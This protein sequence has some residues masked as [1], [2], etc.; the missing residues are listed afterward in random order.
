MP[1]PVDFTSRFAAAIGSTGPPP[2]EAVDLVAGA[3]AASTPSLPPPQE[4]V[5]DRSLEA[6]WWWAQSIAAEQVAFLNHETLDLWQEAT[7][8][9]IDCAQRAVATCPHDSPDRL[10]MACAAADLVLD[11][12]TY[13]P[14]AI[15]PQLPKIIQ[16]LDEHCALMPLA[17]AAPRRVRAVP[18]R[19]AAGASI[20]DALITLAASSEALE[21][22]T[23]TGPLA[24]AT[25]A[26]SRVFATL[27]DAKRALALLDQV[28]TGL[29]ADPA[30]DGT[31]EHVAVLVDRA[32]ALLELGHAGEAIAA[33]DEVLALP[34]D[35]LHP[36]AQLNR[37]IARLE[38][39]DAAGAEQDVETVVTAAGGPEPIGWPI[40]AYLRARIAAALDRNEARSA[41]RFAALLTRGMDLEW[42]TLAA[43][44]AYESDKSPTD[45]LEAYRTMAS[46]IAESRR[47]SLGYRL[48][49]T[50]LR[51]KEAPLA[52]AVHLAADT[53]DWRTAL[54]IIESFKA[55]ELRAILADQRGGIG[56]PS[57]R[58]EQVER[59]IDALEFDVPLVADPNARHQELLAL[60]AERVML[61][62]QDDWRRSASSGLSPS[63][64]VPVD[65]IVAT[66]STAGGAAVDL[67]LDR[68]TNILTAVGM[69]AG[70]A[71]VGS[72]TLA[73]EV[74][75][76]IMRR[77]ENLRSGAP[78]TLLFD[79]SSYP[80]ITAE[81]VLPGVVLAL[82]DGATEILISPHGS[83]HLLSWPAI[84]LGGRR[85][86]EWSVVSLTPSLWSHLLLQPTPARPSGVVAFGAPAGPVAEVLGWLPG[87][88][89]ELAVAVETFQTTGL[90]AVSMV[91]PAATEQA[92]FGA[93]AG[94]TAPGTVL[95]LA[96]HAT[97]G[98]D[99]WVG[100]RP[101]L[102]GAEDPLSAALVLTNGSISADELRRRDLSF[103]EVI[104]GACSTGWR[105]TS[106]GD[107]ELLA[108][109]ALGLVASVLQAGAS[110][111]IASIPPAFDDVAPDLMRLYHRYRLT[112]A[113]P[114]AALCRAQ[115][116]L[117]AAGTHDPAAVV[118]FVAFGR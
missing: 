83:L 35:F 47:S 75:E 8:K 38:S 93:V 17:M 4:L 30:S 69:R 89:A 46:V 15:G 85:L 114:A 2:Q 90:P 104:L 16:A 99:G 107:V 12:C 18:M 82:L 31:T 42:R 5:G 9:A 63:S 28:S 87:A 53:G 103:A 29:R 14:W 65:D 60:R 3:R 96:C 11:A 55:R 77:G 80:A 70:T 49:S 109:T 113:P 73:P 1:E 39:G 68:S 59:R 61:L 24:E 76:A 34:Q 40:V 101:F 48:D 32:M 7:R 36:H 23:W 52:A 57:D 26:T 112:G 118:G 67:H 43:L 50:A 97:T 111:V 21:G 20:A 86:L 62:E 98:S 41:L 102:D 117:L 25:R 6:R 54:E 45:A 84:E 27:G 44:G 66:L 37:G 72:T 105:P 19:L 94:A 13:A 95:H 56:P 81:D 74:V 115:A 92:F 10:A 116:E 79:P 71:V 108:D 51:D 78:D 91:G 58:L 88:E 106:V 33:L 110:S 64:G 22:T 100:G